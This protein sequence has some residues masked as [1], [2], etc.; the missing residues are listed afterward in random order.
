MHPPRHICEA[1]GRKH[2]DLR[3]AW[4]GTF[5]DDEDALNEGCFVVLRLLP[6][7]AIGPMDD[8]FV[9]QEFWDVETVSTGPGEED[10]ECVKVERGPVFSRTGEVRRDWDPLFFKP[11]IEFACHE[12]YGLSTQNVFNG[13]L[14]YWLTKMSH[15]E[16]A[17]QHA[18]KVVQDARDFATLVDSGVENSLDQIWDAAKKDVHSTSHIARKHIEPSF[19]QKRADAGQLDTKKWYLNKKG[20]KEEDA[21]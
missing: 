9:F 20:I 7:E 4:W 19:S 1:L 5:S 16:A 18:A 13:S 8:P 21:L 10:F 3:L 6:V 17:R 12:S 2:P 15:R 11:V 14:V